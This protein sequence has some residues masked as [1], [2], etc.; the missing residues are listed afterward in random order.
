MASR[1]WLPGA[2]TGK[3]LVP[4]LGLPGTIKGAPRSL[5]APLVT[6]NVFRPD[7]KESLCWASP[8]RI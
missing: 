2:Q 1:P 7:R 4:L 5:S 8:Q 6:F 3:I